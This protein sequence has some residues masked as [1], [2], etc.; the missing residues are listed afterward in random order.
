MEQAK[1]E[2]PNA[3]VE[4][5]V[6]LFKENKIT[7]IFCD[8]DGTLPRF[9]EEGYDELEKVVKELYDK[10]VEV[11]IMTGLPPQL[12]AIRGVSI[13]GYMQEGKDTMKSHGFIG[14]NNGGRI[15]NS[16]GEVV[17][18]AEFSEEELSLVSDFLDSNKEG[19]NFVGSSEHSEPFGYKFWV[20]GQESEV[21]LPPNFMHASGES[22]F[23]ELR[24]YMDFVGNNNPPNFLMNHVIGYEFKNGEGLV[25]VENEGATNILPK[26]GGKDAGVKWIAGETNIELENV[27]VIGNDN[28]DLSMFGLNGVSVVVVGDLDTVKNVQGHK[29][30]RVKDPLETVKLLEG[31]AASF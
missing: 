25:L 20:P 8:V 4:Q 24:E 28:N 14:C 3:G 19:L 12:L 10:G 31:Y 17:H 13:P 27:A 6:E 2:L 15:F 29:V 1:S 30:R 11:V 5:A 7:K 21:K 16:N 26:T 18:S 9:G 22:K 23:S